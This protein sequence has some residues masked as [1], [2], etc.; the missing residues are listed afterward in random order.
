LKKPDTHDKCCK[1]VV[2]AMEDVLDAI[3]FEFIGGAINWTDE[4]FD[5]DW[6]NSL[7]EFENNVRIAR[8]AGDLETVHRECDWIKVKLINYCR[9]YK[10][11]KRITREQI[12]FNR[13]R[14]KQPVQ[15]QFSFGNV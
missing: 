9:Q 12:F 14:E 6:S 2:V 7:D 1:A 3:S 5:N 11:I 8:D 4:N 15:E 10:E 13:I